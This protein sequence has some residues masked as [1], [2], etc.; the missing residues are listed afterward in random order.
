[1][2]V[3]TPASWYTN[4]GNGSSTG[5]YAVPLWAL[6]TV[7][8]VGNIIRQKTTPAVGSERCFICIVAGTSSNTTEPT[9]VTTKGAKTNDT[10]PL[11][12]MECTGNP[13]L[14]NDLPHTP[15]SSQNR[16]GAQ[17]LGNII[18]DNSQ[19]H[20]FICTTSGTTGAGEPTYVT[21]AVGN[22]TTDSG[23]TWTYIGTSFGSWAAP[24]ARI[25]TLN[26]I[27]PVG[28]VVY[29]SSAHAETQSTANTIGLGG[30]SNQAP[31][32]IKCVANAG[33]FPPTAADITTG[34]TVTTTGNSG[35]TMS[36]NA[37]FDGIA[38]SCGNSSAPT[39]TIGSN[40][41]PSTL[42]FR[43]CSLG[44]PSSGASII[45]I[46]G[47]VELY[48]T[49]FAFGTSV[50]QQITFSGAQFTWR[51][52]PSAL[53]AG[54]WP[55]TLFAAAT[56]AGCGSVFIENVDLSGF[57]GT[58]LFQNANASTTALRGVFKRSKVPSGVFPSP[59]IPSYACG[60]V[61]LVMCDTGGNTYNSQRF[62]PQGQQ[63]IATTVYAQ[64]GGSDGTTNYAWKLTTQSS[65]TWTAPFECMPLSMWNDT[66]TG[67]RTVTIKGAFVGT[68][69]PNNDDIWFDVSY[70]GTSSSVVGTRATA[71]KATLL[72][73]NSAW[74]ADTTDWSLGAGARANTH[75]YVAGDALAISSSG[76]VNRCF[77]CTTAGTSSGSLPGGYASAVDGSQITDGTA[78]FTAV[79]R[80]TMTKLLSTPQPQAKGYFEILVRSGRASST[81]F[82]DPNPA[83]T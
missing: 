38:F 32:S 45:A 5:H 71:S 10:A 52:T 17:A 60:T 78:V 49:T 57:S 39:F 54:T 23:C 44:T 27:V 47:V 75:A 22:T 50:N 74:S 14:N 6:N 72:T 83:I 56:S 29:V 64:S 70:F 61:D 19:T 62:G 25:A 11:V 30:A 36:G 7:Y 16:S 26:G 73:T 63:T 42:R 28:G 77:V 12:W 66:N 65:L 2:T 1:M 18:T 33:T 34:A 15:L 48:N 20:I 82:V 3:T 21:T 53:S 58:S 41:T 79:W 13:A 68:A 81:F 76:S 37:D 67:N 59:G 80:F 31:V 24:Y 4:Y 40:S 9:W 8:A 55:T 46:V 51:D 35:I 69:A 43:N